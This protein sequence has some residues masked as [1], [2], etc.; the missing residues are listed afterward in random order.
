V[1]RR[2][3]AQTIA[4]QDRQSLVCVGCGSPNSKFP[5]LTFQPLHELP[6]CRQTVRRFDD[7]EPHPH[8]AEQQNY[9]QPA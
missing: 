2:P 5:P 1:Y 7:L 4:G 3:H 6:H 8:M 9:T